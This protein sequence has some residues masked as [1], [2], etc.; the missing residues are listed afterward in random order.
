MRPETTAT[1]NSGAERSEEQTGLILTTTDII[2]L[3]SVP[4]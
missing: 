4:V 1:C 3:G 2:W